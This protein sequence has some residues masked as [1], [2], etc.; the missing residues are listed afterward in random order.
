MNKAYKF[1]D[2]D[3]EGMVVYSSP[4]LEAGLG[5]PKGLV[6][7]MGAHFDEIDLDSPEFTLEGYEVHI[8]QCDM[9]EMMFGNI[10]TIPC[11]AKVYRLGKPEGYPDEDDLFLVLS[12][13]GDNTGVSFVGEDFLKSY[14]P[15]TGFTDVTMIP[16]G[17]LGQFFADWAEIY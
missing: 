8:G 17:Q 4:K 6:E 14:D 3:S 15:D 13:M 2:I 5:Y 11:T 9:F 12:D 10:Q 1:S 16:N 7:H